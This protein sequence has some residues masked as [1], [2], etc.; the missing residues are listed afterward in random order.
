[1]KIVTASNGKKQVKISKSEWETI[2]RK[3]GWLKTAMINMKEGKSGEDGYWHMPQPEIKPV[4]RKAKNA[5]F[6]GEGFEGTY[7]VSYTYNGGIIINDELYKGFKVPPPI[8]PDG[9]E[10]VSIGVGLQLNSHP[11][12]ATVY[13]KKKE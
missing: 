10:L 3:A 12:Y 4:S 11:P 8:V 13:V 5:F 6:R 1:M 9:Y 2:G 7:P